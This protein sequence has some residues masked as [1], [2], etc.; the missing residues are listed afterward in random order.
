MIGVETVISPGK[1][2]IAGASP[3]SAFRTLLPAVRLEYL[4]LTRRLIVGLGTQSGS[5]F[6]PVCAARG[7][8]GDT[9][10][11]GAALLDLDISP[12]CDTSTSEIGTVGLVELLFRSSSILDAMGR[13]RRLHRAVVQ[14]T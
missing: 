3:L 6:V 13:R 2:Q 14:G 11:E 9:S 8:I 12:E 7:L 5:P 10:C 1:E 4:C